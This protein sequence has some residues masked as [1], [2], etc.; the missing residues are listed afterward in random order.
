M[1]SVHILSV[2]GLRSRRR[3]ITIHITTRPCASHTGALLFKDHAKH[4]AGCQRDHL[5]ADRI[6]SP[7]N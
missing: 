3:T 1:C 7:T 2:S 5:G 6:R 4:L